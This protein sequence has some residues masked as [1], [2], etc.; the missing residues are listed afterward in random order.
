MAQM[1]R[2]LIT[3]VA[4]ALAAWSWFA[5]SP[6]WFAWAAAAG[7]FVG[8]SVLAEIIFRRLASPD[9]VRADLEDRVRNPPL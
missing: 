4:M 6:S 8:G 1:A 2:L 3:L 9:A 5:L 7:V